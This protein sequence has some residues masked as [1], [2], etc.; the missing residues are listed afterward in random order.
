MASN[1]STSTPSGLEMG[2]GGELRGRLDEVGSFGGLWLL[3]V[4]VLAK[5][6]AAGRANELE[7]VAR[8]FEVG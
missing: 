8:D 1:S 5:A 2:L 7:G 3:V 4:I 6:A